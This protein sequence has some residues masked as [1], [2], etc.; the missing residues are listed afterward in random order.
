MTENIR[1]SNDGDMVSKRS[2][3]DLGD[4]MSDSEF[5]IRMRVMFIDDVSDN[6]KLSDPPTNSTLFSKN[7]TELRGKQPRLDKVNRL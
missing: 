2:G 1:T 7:F 5:L 3:T 4:T 6:D